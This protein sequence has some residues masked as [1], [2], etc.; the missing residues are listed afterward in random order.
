MLYLKQDSLSVNAIY[1]HAISR[2]NIYFFFIII[3][4][5]QQN[6]GVSF[7]FLILQFNCLLSENVNKEL[8]SK[9]RDSMRKL[10]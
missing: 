9:P 6:E 2:R 10:R 5:V 3:K 8:T 4:I 1:L 7:Y